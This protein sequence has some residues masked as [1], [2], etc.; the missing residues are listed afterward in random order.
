M[1]K[2][3]NMGCNSKFSG[4]YVG[5]HVMVCQLP[6]VTGLFNTAVRS[7]HRSSAGNASTL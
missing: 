1:I 3:K 7:Q 2:V 6:L 5:N 4:S